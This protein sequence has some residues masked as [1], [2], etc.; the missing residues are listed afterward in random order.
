MFL[1][2]IHIVASTSTSFIWLKNISLSVSTTICLSIHILVDIWVV[3]NLLVTMISDALNI[4]VQGFECLFS[5]LLDI[6]L[7]VE[8]LIIVYLGFW[9]I[10]KQF[11]TVIAPFYIPTTNVWVFQH[12]FILTNTCLSLQKN[13]NHAC[14][15]E[16]L[17]HFGFAL[18][19]SNDAVHHFML[20]YHLFMYLLA[21][22]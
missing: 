11:S 17:S 12:L 2:F 16:V 19:L 8:L 15:C 1:R 20:I 21:I 13:Y 18:H 22:C 14:R 5:I 7:G 3:S 9:G 4:C 6:Q 10:G